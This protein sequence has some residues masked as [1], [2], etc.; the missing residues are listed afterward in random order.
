MTASI[1]IG[2]TGNIG[3]RLISLSKNDNLL[4]TSR[5]EKKS[6]FKLDPFNKRELKELIKKSKA[7]SVLLLS[8]ISNVEECRLNPNYSSK[9][10]IELPKIVAEITSECNIKMIFVSTEYIYDGNIKFPKIESEKFIQPKNIYA[11]QKYCAEK[12][13]LEVN[14]NSIVFR[15]PKVYNI[16]RC[17]NFVFDFIYNYKGKKDR[18]KVANDQIFSPLSCLDLQVILLKSIKC[19]LKGV[20]NCGGPES[21]SR[22]YFIKDIC[23]YFSLDVDLYPVN[24]HQICKDKTLPLNIAM[25]SSKLYKAIDYIPLRLKDYLNIPLK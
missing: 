18:V 13:I 25:D 20:Y 19:D 6:L 4:G 8:A 5:N 10:N 11:L 2:A 14:P 3:E 16:Y 7:K 17:G 23:N 22:Y 12:I 24:L 15:L 21:K 9:V 1:I